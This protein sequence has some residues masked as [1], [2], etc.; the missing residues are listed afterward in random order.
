VPALTLTTRRFREATVTVVIGV[1]PHKG[2]HTA[3]AIDEH[4]QQLGRIRVRSGARQL[5]QLLAWAAAFDD[6][7]WAVESAGGLGY[8]LAQQLVGAHERVLDVPATLASR[9]RVLATS[10]SHK[11]DPHDALS[12]AIAALRARDLRPVERADHA[13]VLRLLA[14]R[15]RDLGRARNRSACR[16]HALL[17]ELVPGGISK[18]ITVNA[19]QALLDRIA[20]TNPVAR[21][22]HD[23]ACEHL[24][25]LRHLDAQMRASKRR[26]EAAVRASNTTVTD[27]F[28]VGPVVA[29]MV[30][31]H[32]RNIDRFADRDHFAAYAGTAPIEFASGGRSIR[33]LSLRGNR[34]LNHAIHIA[35]VTQIRHRHS[36]GRA[37]YDRKLAAGKTKK[38]SLRALKRRITDALYRQLRADAAR[39]SAGPG[40]QAGT[41][42]QSSVAGFEPRTPT[43]RKNHS[44]TPP[45]ARTGPRRAPSATATA[46]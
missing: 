15:H 37:F 3:V 34:Q 23:L 10:K 28:G 42:H 2:S 5:E 24:E 8:L 43:L 19:A 31:G 26:L 35:A 45:N 18:E 11:T 4:E 33:R 20:P 40:G 12:V 44:R 27:I 30:I 16:L 6:R 21:I 9:V 39:A 41:T 7:V 17:I 32:A 22:R 46:T 36:P 14:K 38:E 25:D 29:A 1:D 13:V